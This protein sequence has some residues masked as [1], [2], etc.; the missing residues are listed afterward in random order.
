MLEDD[1]STISGDS[2]K[3]LFGRIKDG[4]ELMTPSQSQEALVQP[5]CS[6]F[7]STRDTPAKWSKHGGLDTPY[8][9]RTIPP[10]ISRAIEPDLFARIPAELR[11]QIFENALV[12]NDEILDITTP[13]PDLARVSQKYRGEALGIYY[14]KNMFNC[15]IE[16]YQHKKL[17]R[18][19]T[20]EK[21]YGP[22]EVNFYHNLTADTTTLKDNLRCCIHAAYENEAFGL[23]SHQEDRDD[24]FE[25]SVHED[26]VARLFS[27]S[28]FLRDT[29]KME[30]GV[31]GKLVDMFLEVAGVC[32]EPGSEELNW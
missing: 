10:A 30:W 24:W 21:L 1:G 13:E 6:G 29:H 17:R 31:A 15:T 12:Q 18:L 7:G 3:M 2:V 11:N 14:R 27:Y 8:T 5:F 28:Q 4:P 26:R 19:H 32:G 9:W 23:V 25:W 22:L 20:L 16:N